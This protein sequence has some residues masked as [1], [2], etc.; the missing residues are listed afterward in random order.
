MDEVFY[1]EWLARRPGQTRD[2]GRAAL[3][4]EALGIA[5][6]G[7][8]V[9]AVVGSKGKGTAATYASACLAAAG[10]RVCAVT[11]PGYRSDR[12]RVRV[13]G[14]SLTKAGFAALASRLRAER[15]TLPPPEHGY[16]APTG[17]FTLA[18]VLHARDVDADVLVLE[19]GMGGRSDEISLFPADAVALTPIFGEHLGKLGGTVAEIAAEKAGV[20]VRET[21]VVVSAPQTPDVLNVLPPGHTRPEDLPPD[22]LPHGL[23]SAAA[24]TGW[25]AALRLL[26]AEGLPRPS[27][28]RSREVMGSITL[29]GRLSWHTLPGTDVELLADAAINGAGVTA[30]LATAKTRW[31][32]IDHVL[33]CLPDHKDLDGAISALG[34]LPAT[35]VRLPYARL[36]FDHP[37][38]RAWKVID[39]AALTPE[40]LPTLGRRLLALGTVY[41]IGHVLDLVKADTTR[42]FRPDG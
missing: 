23:A 28:R 19:A 30:A 25:T 5:R 15:D 27:G 6:A 20:I 31:D 3:L 8:P 1:G 22:L 26:D 42:T 16:L 38:P 17:L 34:D 18:G 10:L 14:R 35:F 2:I 41:F 40:A 21:R 39:S 7:R 9:L 36:S 32:E 12:E 11:S 24:A 37:L 13:D 4:A 33:V 29:P